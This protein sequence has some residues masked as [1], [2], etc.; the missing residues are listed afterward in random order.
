M[1]RRVGK[2]LGLEAEPAA[3]SETQASLGEVGIEYRFTKETAR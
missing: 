1:V 2:G 3:G